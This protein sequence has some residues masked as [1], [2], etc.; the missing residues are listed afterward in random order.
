LVQSTSG[1][2]PRP[3]RITARR[4]LLLLAAAWLASFAWLAAGGH[5]VAEPLALLLIFGLAFPGLALVATRG[6]PAPAA[7]AA[8]AGEGK[9]LAAL[10]LLVTLFL[11][12]KGPLLALL[13]PADPDPRLEAVVNLLLK[14]TVL[15]ALPLAAYAR[16]ARLRPSALGLGWPPGPA[17]TRGRSWLALLLVGG[18]L[19]AVQLLIGRGARPLLDGSLAGRQWVLG[20]V[21]AFLW[22]SLEAGFV[23]ETFFRVLLQSRLAALAGSPAAGLF[24]SALLF[25]L[26]HAPGLWLRGGGVIEGL[27][28]AP[29]PLVALAY[30]VTTM[31]VAGL[32]FGVLWLRT[33]NWLLL[34]VL[35]GLTDALSNTAGFMER[36]GL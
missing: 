12:G 29:S 19:V 24:L 1:R 33:R 20:L 18:G 9:L 23:E 8:R 6:L 4:A 34:V 22:M 16:L 28:A 31:A 36:W 35:H 30:S 17:A 27:G 3:P 10:L 21:L 26:A 11:A 25:G 15:V 7:D 2:S 13:L 5:P 14:L 32:V